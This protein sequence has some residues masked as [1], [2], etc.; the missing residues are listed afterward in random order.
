MERSRS[1]QPLKICA[2][3]AANFLAT[4]VIVEFARHCRNLQSLQIS[5]ELGY[6]YLM[7]V[8]IAG[9]NAKILAQA[10]GTFSNDLQID[11][12]ATKAACFGLLRQTDYDLIVACEMLGDGSGLEVLSHV[13]V[14]TPNTLRIF[15]ARPATLDLLKGELGLFGLYRTLPYPI[16]FRKLWAAINLA[17]STFVDGQLAPAAAPASTAPA[18]ANSQGVP[19]QNAQ[20]RGLTARATARAAQA[21][22]ALAAR[23]GANL[24]QAA[25]ASPSRSAAN[26]MQASAAPSA[27]PAA[28]PGRASNA[29]AASAVA[30]ATPAAPANANAGQQASQ[31]QLTSGTRAAARYTAAHASSPPSAV[32]V[33]SARQAPQPQ[34]NVF[35]ARPLA[36]I[37][38]S[39]A[40]KRAL[41]KRNAARLEANS[42]FGPIALP[43]QARTHPAGANNRG[44]QR[45]EPGITHDSLVQLAKMA[46][47]GRSASSLRGAPTGN[48]RAALF[49]GSGVFAAATAAVLTFFMVNANNSVPRSKL[50]RIASASRP[51]PNK[52]FPWQPEAQQP[53]Q[54][55]RLPTVIRSESSAPSAAD[56]EV[57]AEAASE[58]T[59]GEPIPAPPP[60]QPL[61]PPPAQEPPSEESLAESRLALA[62]LYSPDAP[63]P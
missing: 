8:L 54:P 26:S 12:A 53:Q 47:T 16:N 44:R 52:I 30:K 38:Q 57:E 61:R 13:C 25:A 2:P 7:R 24:A 45:R 18:R 3:R 36:P 11:T 6:Y 5:V 56:L 19:P 15:A 59:D 58:T 62:H 39:D 35:N 4:R 63:T 43:T 27:R 23:S 9:R 29:P 41:A 55:T 17:R 50:P 37:P 22:N 46:A 14:N 34:G 21:S 20:L 32:T 1:R 10:A 40:F 33:T 48:K 60:P 28:N 42:D 31:Q 49:V 51:I